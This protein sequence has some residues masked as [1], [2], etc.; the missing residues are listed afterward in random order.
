MY[1]LTSLFC[2]SVFPYP[3]PPIEENV[4]DDGKLLKPWDTKKVA[5]S[6]AMVTSPGSLCCRALPVALALRRSDRHTCCILG[7]RRL[8]SDRLTL[9][10]FFSIQLPLLSSRPKSCE[11]PG[12][13]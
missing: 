5:V 12:I 4:L 13:K 3:V 9:F 7:R 2:P 1:L 11:V 6:I 8:C 10:L